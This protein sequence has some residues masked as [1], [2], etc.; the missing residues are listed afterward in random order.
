MWAERGLNGGLGPSAVKHSVPN[1]PYRDPT[2]RYTVGWP[3][4]ALSCQTEDRS[5]ERPLTNC[6]FRA[7]KFATG[8]FNQWFYD[9]F[10]GFYF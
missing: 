5:Q 4:V 8:P 1:N 9:S 6:Q 3:L 7:V 10:H 2:G